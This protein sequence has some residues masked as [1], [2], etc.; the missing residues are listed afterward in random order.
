MVQSPRLTFRDRLG[1]MLG[2][3][4]WPGLGCSFERQSGRG[5]DQI[6]PTRRC[7]F[8]V[9]PYRDMGRNGNARSSPVPALELSVQHYQTG[10]RKAE[11]ASIFQ[12]DRC[13]YVSCG[14]ETHKKVQKRSSLCC[15][16]RDFLQTTHPPATHSQLAISQDR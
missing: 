9:L 2:D 7:P 6:S 13:M 10:Q 8:Q 15:N 11:P 1:P 16:C 14:E 4:S 12:T 3:M 5:G